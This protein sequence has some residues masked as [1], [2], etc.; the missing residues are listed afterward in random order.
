MIRNP[1]TARVLLAAILGG[2]ATAALAQVSLPPPPTV[3]IFTLVSAPLPLAEIFRC[4]VTNVSSQSVTLTKLQIYSDT[5][6]AHATCAGSGA[7]LS[8]GQTCRV[9]T[10]YNPYP[11]TITPHCRAQFLGVKAGAVVGSLHS[12][13]ASGG[14]SPAVAAV[15]MQLVE[16]I[17]LAP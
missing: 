7:T 8:P 16:G 9:Q 17:T 10:P 1:N 2:A 5:V 6:V 15:P 4:Q 12:T 3:A 11:G 14:S 13:Y